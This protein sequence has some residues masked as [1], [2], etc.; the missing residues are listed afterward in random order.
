MIWYFYC[1]YVL[2]A[3]S[4]PNPFYFQFWKC[5][6][7]SK[8]QSHFRRLFTDLARILIRRILFLSAYEVYAPGLNFLGCRQTEYSWLV[9]VCQYKLVCVLRGQGTRPRKTRKKDKNYFFKRIGY[10]VTSLFIFW[11]FNIDV[12]FIS[13]NRIL[14]ILQ[15]V[16]GSSE[17]WIQRAPE[18]ISPGLVGSLVCHS[19]YCIIRVWHIHTVERSCV[20]VQTLISVQREVKM[21]Q[22]RRM[23]S[24]FM[25]QHGSLDAGSALTD[26][27]SLRTV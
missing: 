7:G 1:I 20:A 6:G 5:D 11:V 27:R 25:L 19:Q 14:K 21:K 18:Q 9:F 23:A 2:M 17:T 15:E 4:Q 8:Q 3:G 24:H 13:Y 16:S 26:A 22:C 10:S 12:W